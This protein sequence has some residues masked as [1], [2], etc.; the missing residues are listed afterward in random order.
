VGAVA[1]G[2]F[3][4]GPGMDL[5][6][7]Q[8]EDARLARPHQL[9]VLRGGPAP[10]KVFALPT[11]VGANRLA[12]ADLDLDGTPELV[13]AGAQRAAEQVRL[14]GQ[15]RSARRSA[16]DVPAAFALVTAD[17]DGD[18]H[19]DVVFAA[20][21]ARLVLASRDPA[22]APRAIGSLADWS[23]VQALD[24]NDDGRLDLIGQRGQALWGMIQT[25]AL[26]FEARELARLPAELTVHAV[27]ALS[28]ASKNEARRLVV[29]SSYARA[30]SPV[31]LQVVAALSDAG[32]P[33]HSTPL[34]DAALPQHSVFP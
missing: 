29:V 33:A 7:L 14:E 1:A 9:L 18:G 19:E 11:A 16:L 21:D 22:R 12:V 15:A 32:G 6:V 13:L 4:P 20:P 2:A 24:W 23:F 8:L 17:M 5:A 34:P 28:G 26:V 31:E 10:L 27:Q 25:G 3:D 30:S